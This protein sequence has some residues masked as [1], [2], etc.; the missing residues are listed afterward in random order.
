[1]THFGAPS[2]S[3]ASEAPA[4]LCIEAAVG[5]PGLTGGGGCE[6]LHAANARSEFASTTVRKDECLICRLLIA[7][8]SGRFSMV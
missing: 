4:A 1:M 2:N 8:T 6:V 3:A 5:G 7:R